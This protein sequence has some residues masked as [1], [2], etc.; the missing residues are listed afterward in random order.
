MLAQRSEFVREVVL[1]A[2]SRGVDALVRLKLAS[3]ADRSKTVAA[4]VPSPEAIEEVRRRVKAHLDRTKPKPSYR[5]DAAIEEI[6]R[7]AKE[8]GVELARIVEEEVKQAL[9]KFPD[10]KPEL[11]DLKNLDSGR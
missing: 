8:R 10:T 11:Y 9:K 4:P 5:E 3:L 6:A 2:T 7:F 1:D